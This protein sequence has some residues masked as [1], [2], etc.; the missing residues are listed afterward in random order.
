MKYSTEDLHEKYVSGYKIDEISQETGISRWA[1][2]KRFQRIKNSESLQENNS[3]DN[4]I[5]ENIISNTKKF[6]TRTNKLL[7][8]ISVM[9]V[10]AAILIGFFLYRKYNPETRNNTE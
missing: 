7:D 4:V 10:F 9:L 8:T 3:E 6:Q 1:L 5:Q 2:Y